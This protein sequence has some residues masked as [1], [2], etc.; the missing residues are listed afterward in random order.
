M[1]W[2]DQLLK[3]LE[4]HSYAVY[5][6]A[7][8]DDLLHKISSEFDDSAELF[9]SAKIGLNLKSQDQSVRRDSILW[10]EGTTDV[11][12]E[13][14]GLLE[15]VRLEL[16][17][18]LFL[19]IKRFETHYA[20]YEN[21][22]FYKKHK[23][24]ESGEIKRVVTFV[25]YLNKD[26]KPEQGGE[27]VLYDSLGKDVMAIVTPVWGRLVWFLSQEIPHEV[28]PSF[29]TRKSLTGWMRVDDLTY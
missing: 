25:L 16:N 11:Q 29:V 1:K 15:S 7:L 6:N 8:S 23:D 13:W 19:G 17:Q 5:S 21:S 3:D 27:L 4:T 20:R 10:L 24:Q 26:W 9:V 12:R 28:K 14:F 18:K 2:R 22:G